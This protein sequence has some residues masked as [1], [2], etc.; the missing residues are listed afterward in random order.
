VIAQRRRPH[1]PLRRLAAL[2]LPKGAVAALCALVLALPAGLALAHSAKLD[3]QGRWVHHH[4][5][6]YSFCNHIDQDSNLRSEATNARNQWDDA[7]A[8]LTFPW[9]AECH[10]GPGTQANIQLQDG[11]LG[12][13]GW[14]SS[15]INDAGGQN[16]GYHA[17]HT[18]VHFNLDSYWGAYGNYDRRALICRELG[19]VIGVD[20]VYSGQ[21]PAHGADNDC[22]SFAANPNDQVSKI[23]NDT[24]FTYRDRPWDHSVNLVADRYADH[25]LNLELSGPLFDLRGADL[26]D[27][28][29]ELWVSTEG[30]AK[31]TRVLIEVDGIPSMEVAEPCAVDEERCTED[32]VY[33]MDTSAYTAGQHVVS[34]KVWDAYGAMTQRTFSVQIVDEAEPSDTYPETPA[35]VRGAGPGCQADTVRTQEEGVLLVVHGTWTDGTETTEYFGEGDYVLSRCDAAGALVVEQEVATIVLDNGQEIPVEEGRLDRESGAHYW[36]HYMLYPD[37]SGT[38]PAFWT[39]AAEGVISPTPYQGDMPSS[40]LALGV[41]TPDRGCESR[42]YV[43]KRWRWN[44]NPRYRIHRGSLPDGAKSKR[45]I[46]QAHEAWNETGD[47]CHMKD[48][49]DFR[50]IFDGLTDARINLSDDRDTIDFGALGEIG[51]KPSA[52]ACANP[53]GFMNDNGQLVL[54][55]VDIRFNSNPGANGWYSGIGTP[56]ST[57]YDLRS[58]ATHE[59]GHKLGLGHVPSSNDQAMCSFRCARPGLTFRRTLGRGDVRGMRAR[60]NHRGPLG[61][62][63]R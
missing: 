57:K 54:D 10:E 35:A 31:I 55:E 62:D 60:Y 25:V 45:R 11:Y 12:N 13:T 26:S 44:F 23:E 9:R 14:R 61:P 51:C 29:Y 1:L 33:Q 21:W 15:A 34:I 48:T 59:A 52:L 50:M 56:P 40:A 30:P 20:R 38:T 7:S 37:P 24:N 22:M 63:P 41:E 43:S 27:D 6:A 3:S 39:D 17:N 53:G 19:Q 47:S 4:T 5:T 18:H 49:T 42:Q 8:V 46:L 2:E 16:L 36:G 28:Q 58:T 32:V